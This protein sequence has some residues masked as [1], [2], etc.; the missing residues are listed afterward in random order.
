MPK[1]KVHENVPFNTRGGKK[2]VFQK[3]AWLMSAGLQQGLGGFGGLTRGQSRSC[4]C[5]F[6]SHFLPDRCE[7]KT[8]KKKMSLQRFQATRTPLTLGRETAFAH[9]A[10]HIDSISNA[11]IR[12]IMPEVKSVYSKASEPIHTTRLEAFRCLE[13]LENA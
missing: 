2:H 1:S 12:L 10:N 9:Y 6:P 3:Y 8:Q 4:S 5:R 7:Q 11:F 13:R